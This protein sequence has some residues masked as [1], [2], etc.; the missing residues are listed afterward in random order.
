MTSPTPDPS[1]LTLAEKASLTSGSATWYSTGAGDIPRLMLTDGPHGLRRQQEGGDNLGIGDSVPATCFPPAVGLGSSWNVDLARRIGEA[2][3]RE[4]REQGVHVLLGPGM[5]IKRS[6]LGGRNFEYVS[7]DPHITGRIAAALVRGIQSRGVAAT[8]KHFAVNNQ[9]T[10]RMRVSADVDERTLREIYL[11]AFEHVVTEAR[12]WALMSSYNRINGVFASE[13]HSLQTELLRG[14]WGFDGVVMSDWGAVNDR[15]AAVSSGLDLEM[16][17]SDTDAEIVAAVESGTLDEAVLDTVVERLRL[18]AARTTDPALATDPVDIDAHHRL[19][20]DAAAEAMVLLRNEGGLLPLDAAAGE[21][22]AV[23]GEFA[24]TPRYQGGGSSR[25]VPTRLSTA[26]EEIRSVAPAAS[27]EFAAGFSLETE[28]SDAGTLAAEAL[29]TEALAAEAVAVA[30]RADRVLLFLGL[31]DGYE[32]EGFD[33]ETLALPADQLA[34]LTRVAAL[35]A[36]V[37]V[38]LSNGATVEVADWANSVE[39]ILE[40]WLLGQ[41]GGLA[42]AE[43]LFGLVSPGGR[44]TETIPLRLADTPSYLGFPGRDGH[45]VYGEGVYVGYRHYNTLNTPVAYEFGFGL[46]YTTF[47]YTDL[48][49]VPGETANSWRISVTVQNTGDRDGAEVVQAYVGV[50][51]SAPTRPAQE[52]RG[53]AK[54]HLAAGESGTAV[55]NLDARDFATWDA[56]QHRWRVDAGVFTVQ[57]G[58]SSRHIRLTQAVE[59]SG[60]GW[61]P[62]LSEQSTVGE[63]FAHPVGGQLLQSVRDRMEAFAAGGAPEL[64]KMVEQVPIIKLTSWK[65]GLTLERV[66]EMVA[67]VAA[68]RS[69]E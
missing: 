6:P 2:L 38:I 41:G 45:V 16:P 39:A 27:V 54:L 19:A 14:E 66:R 33:R 69:Q 18:L 1:D 44:L 68:E 8:P 53:F 13:D 28:G 26:L 65:M 64:L 10:D 55:I 56:G 25:V 60:D 7:E 22:I 50:T 52:L 51:E 49:L 40:T 34:L 59:V 15:V 20:A 24:R 48:S 37:V 31:P 4:A 36:P 35:N 62:E 58:S 57:V 12:P 9:E 47:E 23:I 46:T 61:I 67:Y 29:A 63:W 11:P 3:G 43:V 5:N 17:P 30:A 21:R 42:T 32:S